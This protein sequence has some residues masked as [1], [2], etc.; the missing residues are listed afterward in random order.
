MMKRLISTMLIIASFGLVAA[1]SVSPTCPED[2]CVIPMNNYLRARAELES[3]ANAGD[4][5]AIKEVVRQ[6]WATSGESESWI[7]T[8]IERESGFQPW[9]RNASGASGLFQMMLPM[10]NKL[11][12]E[13]GCDPS[14]WAEAR[15]NARAAF[16][17]YQKAGR[18]PWV[19]SD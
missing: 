12:V 5:E 3:K 9:A 14:R 6:E 7:F 15:C 11:F 18:S 8:K 19:S 2:T 10:H 4:R 17:L 1:C 13:A 16:I